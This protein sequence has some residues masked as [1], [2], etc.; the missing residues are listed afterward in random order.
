MTMWRGL[1]WVAAVVAAMLAVGATTQN[2]A[3]QPA[4]RPAARREMPRY[5]AWQASRIGGGGYIQNVVLFPGNPQ[6]CY[7][8]LDV[9]GPYRSDDG[10]NSW[11]SLQGSLPGRRGNYSI[12]SLSVDPRDDKYVIIAV[13]SQWEAREGV[14]ISDNGGASWRRALDA[15]FQSDVFRNAGTVLARHSKDSDIVLAGAIDSG[16]WRSTD[17]GRTW[18]NVGPKD[19]NPTDLRFDV[20]NPQLAW[21]CAHAMDA[22]VN[23]QRRKVNGG[24]F[25]SENGG[26]TWNKIADEAPTEILQD[27]RDRSRLYGIFRREIIKTST[28][29]G[30]S[31]QDCSEGLAIDPSQG[32]LLSEHRFNVLAAGRDFILTASARGTFYRLECGQNTWKKIERQGVDT[33][34]WFGKMMPG[35]FQHFGAEVGSIVVDPNDDDHWF[36]TDWYAMFQTF[37]SGKNWRLTVDGIEGTV[38][39]QLLQDPSDPAVVH[40]SMADNAYFKSTDGGRTFR[41]IKFPGVCA[42]VKDLALSPKLPARVYA[43][44]ADNWEWKSNQ[45]YVSIDTGQSWHRSPMTGLSDMSQ[46]R[47]NSVAVDPANPYTVYLSVSGSIGAGAGGPYRSTDGGKTWAW[48]G[49][50]LPAGQDFYRH[51]IWVTGREIAAGPN[52]SLVT[53][54]QDSALVFHFDPKTNQWAKAETKPMGKPYSVVADVLQAGRYYMGVENGL[55]RSKDSGTT[56]QRVYDREA[57]HVAVDLAVAN[58]A[59]A[60]TSDGVILTRDGGE[61][62]SMLDKSLPDRVKANMPALAGERIVVGSGGSGCFWMPLS[63]DGEKPVKAKPPAVASVPSTNPAASNAAAT[64]RP[65]RVFIE[66]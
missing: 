7:T 9:G 53:I 54:S 24:F 29:A 27:P 25:R 56:W 40:M 5:G 4:S 46:S 50:G 66:K 11:R 60:S 62:W 13:G 8:Y 48:I 33:G 49:Q 65:V 28:D 16:V 32:G 52:G 45:L 23:G 17:N 55:F 21:L 20:A 41:Q 64:T 37:D 44:G 38:V 6:R 34:D 59:A 2:P 30:D 3:T 31:W 22:V 18:E 10:G 61:N 51:D 39:H 47:C 15:N 58:R 35:E 36:F 1:V 14:Y 26:K 63:R 12:R 57:T 42:N 43:V 19:V